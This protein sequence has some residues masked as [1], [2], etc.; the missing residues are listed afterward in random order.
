MMALHLLL[1]IATNKGVTRIQIFGDKLDEWYKP[2]GEFC[3]KV[4]FLGDQNIS[5]LISFDLFSTCI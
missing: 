3:D 5:S 2:Y 4:Y 1:I